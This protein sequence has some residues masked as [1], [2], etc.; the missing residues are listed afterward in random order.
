MAESNGHTTVMPPGMLR[1]FLGVLSSRLGLTSR[2]GWTYGGDRK[3]HDVLG[4]QKTLDYR[5]FKARYLR[6]DIAHRL[7]QAYPE[8]T[9]A[10]PPTV[11]EDDEDDTDTAFEEA[12]EDLV[13]RLRIYAILRRTDVLANLGQYA[14]L[15]IGLRG[16]SRLD[17]P[18]HAVHGPE[19]V[20]YLAPYS[21]EFT[22]I[23]AFED[24]AGLPTFGQPKV[25][26]INTGQA[27]DINR[28]S[29]SPQS[30][31]V[32]ASRII[33][34]AEDILDDE[35]YGIPRLQPIYDKLDDLLKVVGGGAE[36]FWR[37]SRRRIVLSLR[38]G[39]TLTADDAER[40][41]QEAE[42]YAHNERDFIRAS[43]MDVSQLIGTV[44]SPKEHADVI[45]DMIAA[46]TGIPKRILLGSERGQLASVQDDDAWKERVALRQQQFAEAVLLRP[47]I[48][49]LIGL[50]ALP[51]PA[52]PYTVEW[53]NLHSLSEPQRAVVAKDWAAALDTYAGKGMA[54]TIVPPAEFRETY[55]GIAAESEFPMPDLM[56]LDEGAT[57]P[58]A[59]A[60]PA[61]ETPAPAA[62]EGAAA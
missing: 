27:N 53:G 47:L 13:T 59:Q 46:T 52:Q 16:Q 9:W 30:L 49:R 18:A 37:D 23:A 19:D 56:P 44:A 39:Y 40:I 20:L 11:R 31:T 17:Q 54:Q 34:V 14:V 5:D 32:H 22:E 41:Q 8:A 21:E 29:E 48:D 57:S 6:Q 60:P 62:D 15:L 10:Q 50:R 33:H 2:I 45:L 43:G 26:R 7:V 61:E 3:L 58:D 35:V 24:N 42:E 12:W 38:D 4:Y 51:E 55:L 25:Y 36:G 28:R 1:T